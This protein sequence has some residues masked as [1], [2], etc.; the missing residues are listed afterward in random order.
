MEI[1]PVF[2]S[3]PSRNDFILNNNPTREDIVQAKEQ[4][5]IVIMFVPAI[6]RYSCEEHYKLWLDGWMAGRGIEPL[7]GLWLRIVIAP[8]MSKREE[9]LES[10][11]KGWEFHS[12]KSPF[13]GLHLRR[14][15]SGQ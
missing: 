11:F 8:D 4:C 9:I 3:V 12:M 2:C 5:K 7:L 10:F 6:S 15:Q 13:D 1:K 14:N